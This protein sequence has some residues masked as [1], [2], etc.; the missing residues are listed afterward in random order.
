ML[1][2]QLRTAG[3]YWM[4]PRAPSHFVR[5]GGIV[6]ILDARA[7][8]S[9]AFEGKIPNAPTLQKHARLGANLVHEVNGAQ[10]VYTTIL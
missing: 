9:I 6:Q 1:H 5:T 3:P 4:N 7:V 10:D 2:Q 8:R